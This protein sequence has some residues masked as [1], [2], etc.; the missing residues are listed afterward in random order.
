MVGRQGGENLQ[1]HVVLNAGRDLRNGRPK[2]R[3]YLCSFL[4]VLNAG[5]DLRNGR[6]LSQTSR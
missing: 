2:T 1:T 5:R 6:T 4:R 3:P